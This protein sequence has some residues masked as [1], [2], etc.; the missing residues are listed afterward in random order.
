M[1]L[2]NDQNAV[3]EHRDENK[4]VLALPGSG[5]THLSI[6]LA[7]EI[8]KANE[9]NKLIMVTFTRSSTKETEHRISKLISENDLKR[10][11]IRT[12]AK[13]ILDH[14]RPLLDG[15]SLIMGPTHDSFKR[16]AVG[17]DEKNLQFLDTQFPVEY[18]A[19][20]G[21]IGEL[22]EIS[23]KYLQA[24]WQYK[25]VDLTTLSIELI[26]ALRAKKIE[27]LDFTHMLVDEFQD[28]SAIEYAWIKE[29]KKEN[30]SFTVVG[31]DDQ[32]IY[33]WRGGFGYENMVKFQEE[34]EAKAFLLSICFRCAP[35]IL[36]YAAELI[37]YN[38]ER[39]PKSMNSAK[40][41]GGRVVFK[42]YARLDI[43][44]ALKIDPERIHQYKKETIINRIVPSG[45]SWHYR[46]AIENYLNLINQKV[47]A[48]KPDKVIMSKTSVPFEC[49]GVVA[50]EIAQ[51]P[52]GWAVLAR[53]NKLL[54]LMQEE[55]VYLD[56]PVERI[57]GKSIWE[58][59]LIVGLVSLY[60]SL[61]NP[62]S[63][64]FID[65]ALSF[66][67][68]PN[69]V[70]S[71]THKHVVEVGDINKVSSLSLP[72]NKNLNIYLDLAKNIPSNDDEEG[73]D[74]F[75]SKVFNIASVISKDHE[76]AVNKLRLV[77]DRLQ[78]YS[79]SL[80]MRVSALIRLMQMKDEIDHSD[81]DK[82]ILATM[83]GSKGL[84]W[85]KVW[86]I[87]VEKN[88]VPTKFRGDSDNEDSKLAFLEEERRL[89]YVAI[90]RAESLLHIS[91]R[92]G[93]HSQ[94][95]EEMQPA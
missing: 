17:T 6:E 22:S 84:Q 23:M 31:D 30:R 93:K 94:F 19:S 38:V 33:S 11:D 37:D 14:A 56:I 55:L 64:V 83:N 52:K 3:V 2:T 68:V 87:D 91:Y 67:G 15:R 27:P 92:Q 46:R 44:K 43:E 81:K 53:T 57:G 29:N 75:I 90:T 74:E 51:N 59:P 45:L 12:F 18:L 86:I 41:P 48:N 79:G 88:R 82:V 35:E 77:S 89:L 95:I 54:D 39:M 7:S 13:L 60:R 70:I 49:Q 42:D 16:R 65:D 63:I 5:K 8:I 62:K 25:K 47:Y 50:L 80:R 61:S 21:D 4:L 40:D 76:R 58:S 34:F 85:E 78:G 71:E 66:I 69:S 72:E 28:T 32:A 10:I 24:L 1:A 9:I 26:F 73:I 36:A 20:N